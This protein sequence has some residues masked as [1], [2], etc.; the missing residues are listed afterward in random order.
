MSVVS[1]LL[2]QLAS[3]FVCRPLEILFDLRHILMIIIQLVGVI[4]C[5]CLA[6]FLG[7]KFGSVKSVHRM[8]ARLHP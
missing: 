8:Q 2:D 4:L 1:S 3:A 6:F 7:L 5:L